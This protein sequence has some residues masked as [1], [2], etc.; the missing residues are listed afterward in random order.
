MAASPDYDLPGSVAKTILFSRK[1]NAMADQDI[2]EGDPG[3]GRK[4]KIPPPDADDRP[5]KKRPAAGDDDDAPRKKKKVARDEDEGEDLGASPLSAIIPVGGSI[6]AL[7]SLWLSVLAGLMALVGLIY[8]FG[9]IVS[10]LLPSLWVISLLC[11]VL[12]FVTHKH[13]ASYGSIAGNMR[14]I[15]GI[16]ISLGVMVLHGVLVFIFLTTGR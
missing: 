7:L 11:G 6:F 10:C 16:L 15:I 13:K 4:K 9:N 8:F 12:A 1:H 2:R 3:K 14:A 5:R